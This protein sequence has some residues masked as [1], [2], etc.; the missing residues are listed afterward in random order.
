MTSPN[1]PLPAGTCDC[2]VHVFEPARHPY[3]A[4]RAYTPP[5][6]GVEALDTFLGTMG[7]ARVVLVQPSVY[8]D[9]NRCLLDA[10]QRLGLD[11]ARGIAVL[12][13]QRADSSEVARLHEGGVRGLRL[14][15]HVS[16][17][18]LEAARRQIREAGALIAAAPGWHLEVHASL[19]TVVTL[20]DDFARLDRPVVLDHYAGGL[21]TDPASEGQLERLLQAL[22]RQA[23]HIKLSAPYRLWQGAGADQTARLARAFA[24]A[25]P[26]RVLWGSD[27]PHT[28]GSGSRAGGTQAVEPFRSVDNH[29]VLRDLLASLP[30]EE[31]SK[32]LLDTN[33]AALYGLPA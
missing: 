14:N 7:V 23:L 13:P 27:W 8:A 32:R 26:D 2:H 22:P 18:G 11:R 17:E 33:P 4:G 28:G 5:P 31:F 25:A 6:A 19:A 16:G 20:L 12:D 24:L 9:D 15:L 30:D 21:S 29:Q 1:R 10:L 3:A